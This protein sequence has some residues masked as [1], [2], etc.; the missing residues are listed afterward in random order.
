MRSTKD[1][2]HDSHAMTGA[3]DGRI[4]KGDQQVLTYPAGTC[5][6]FLS[7]DDDSP[8]CSLLSSPDSPS[9]SP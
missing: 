3:G 4:G 9:P 1:R 8:P 6:S 5:I 7:S 2:T